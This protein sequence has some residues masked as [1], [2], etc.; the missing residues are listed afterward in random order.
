MALHRIQSASM[1]GDAVRTPEDFSIDKVINGGKFGFGLGN[2]IQ[3]E[4]IFHN[5]TGEHLFETALSLDQALTELP[6]G[7]LRVIATIADT[8]QLI[9][10]LLGFGDGVEIIQPAELRASLSKTAANMHHR[11]T[12]S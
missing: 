6:D 9:W 2:Q 11:Y 1:L 12:Q 3:L 7:S 8:P 4:A 10:W 5:G